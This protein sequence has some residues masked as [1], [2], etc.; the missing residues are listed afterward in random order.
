MLLGVEGTRLQVWA[1]PTLQHPPVR[2]ALPWKLLVD[3][4]WS[5]HPKIALNLGVRCWW[6][7]CIHRLSLLVFS[8]LFLPCFRCC[9]GERKIKNE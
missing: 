9:C 6:C 7:F 5:I 3:T 8:L 4:A 1:D 2:Q